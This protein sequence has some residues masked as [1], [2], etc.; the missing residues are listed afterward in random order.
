MKTN[1]SFCSSICSVLMFAF[2]F[3]C[4][5][6]RSSL[7]DALTALTPLT[8]LP[9]AGMDPQRLSRIPARMQQFVDEEVISGAV[10]LLARRGEVALLSIPGPLSG[11]P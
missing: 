2:I 6:D 8:A 11:S 3:G 4:S 7:P 9:Q 5:S 10:M 1:S